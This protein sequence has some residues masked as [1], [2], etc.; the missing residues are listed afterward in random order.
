LPALD[1]FR[2]AGEASTSSSRASSPRTSL[3]QAAIARRNGA[4]MGWVYETVPAGGVSE[5]LRA[6]EVN[7]ELPRSARRARSSLARDFVVRQEA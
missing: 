4:P 2:L 3:K 6:G 1:S 5:P 7:G